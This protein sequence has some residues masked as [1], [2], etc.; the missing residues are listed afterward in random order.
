MPE[1]AFRQRRLALLL[2]WLVP[3]LWT[4]NYVVARKAPGVIGPYLL[5]LGRW[6]L[7]A[8]VLT[9]FTGRELWSKRAEINRTWWQYVILGTLG[10]LV[11]GAWVYQGAR[12]TGAMNI[13]L[14][15]SASPV[16]IGLGA[17]MW[18][19]ERF[20]WRQGLGVVL[21]LTGVLH[22]VV[23]GQWSQLGAVHFV[24][25]DGWI[26]G[27]TV[28]WAAYALLQKRWPSSLSSSA[29][30]AV[31]CLGGVAV[32]LP[33]ALWEAST[34]GLTVWGLPALL[35]VVVA[36][37]VPGLGAYWIYGWAQKILGASR[38]A[39]SLY[40]GPLYAA[41][42]S[43]WVLG[44][45]PG[46]HHAMGAALILPGVFFVTGAATAVSTPASCKAGSAPPVETP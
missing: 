32:L 10:M 18:L 3:A 7:A 19:G 45:A 24:A 21:A 27:A 41:F 39:V 30:L 26:A 1:A 14:I 43:W 46:L 8:L 31:I 16:L 2:L 15:Y 40:L 34:P 11:C 22:V 28:A 29:R 12:S 6:S 36:G 17:A 23:R 13:A 35:L 20:S 5:A 42:V 44:E 37:L 25:G 9:A 33:C 38:V 4:V